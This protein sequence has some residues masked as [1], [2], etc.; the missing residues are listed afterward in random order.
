MDTLRCATRRGRIAVEHAKCEPVAAPPAIGEQCSANHRIIERSE[1][2]LFS[3]RSNCRKH[4]HCPRLTI[5]FGRLRRK[6]N[7]RSNCLRAK[8][9]GA[10]R[11]LTH[12]FLHEDVNRNN[13]LEDKPFSYASQ[14][15]LQSKKKIPGWR[16]DGNAVRAVG[17]GDGITVRHP[18]S[19]NKIAI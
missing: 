18:G 16:C 2:T 12:N 9:A 15:L 6:F 10:M 5:S 13:S 8:I 17:C 19:A 3:T 14:L 11:G 4:S 7:G 1:P